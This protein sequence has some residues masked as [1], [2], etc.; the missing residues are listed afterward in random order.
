MLKIILLVRYNFAL[1]IYAGLHVDFHVDFLF[2]MDSK[3]V[4]LMF[5]HEFM[6]ILKMKLLELWTNSPEQV[7]TVFSV[8]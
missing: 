8:Y 4:F 2:Y 3:C 7:A 1:L 5:I 6:L